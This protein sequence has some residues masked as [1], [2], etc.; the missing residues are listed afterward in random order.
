MAGVERIERTRHHHRRFGRIPRSIWMSA[1]VRQK[2]GRRLSAAQAV[3]DGCP[4]LGRHT[5]NC[6]TDWKSVLLG[7]ESRGRVQLLA[8]PAEP[9]FPAR[10]GVDELAAAKVGAVFG[11]FLKIGLGFTHSVLDRGAGL[12]M[13]A[14]RL[15]DDPHARPD[16]MA[17]NQP[18]YMAA[19]PVL[20]ALVT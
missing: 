13:V 5:V 20:H 4:W 7:R 1:V 17:R 19:I 6:R 14:R 18:G 8:D 2:D 11:H 15:Q 9:A 12:T 16:F 10:L 3:Q